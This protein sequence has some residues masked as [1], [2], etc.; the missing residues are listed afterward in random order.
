MADAASTQEESTRFRPVAALAIIVLFFAI[1]MG[2]GAVL[3]PPPVRSTN[4][5]DQFNAPAAR[6][7]L[8]RILG[9]GTPHPVDSAAADVTRAALL[10]EIEAL[11]FRPEVRESFI[12]RPQPR[13]PL[14]D[15]ALVRNIVFSIGPATGPAILAATHYDSVPAAPGASDAGIGIAAWLEIARLI[16]H[17][18]LQRRVIFLIG[19]GEEPGLL[20][21]YAFTQS[22]PL[23]ADVQALVNLEAR[24]T[25]GPAIFFE[26]NQPNGDAAAAYASAPRPIANSVMA[27]VYALLSNSTDVTALRRPGLDVINIALLDG[28]EGYHTPQDSLGSFNTASLQH[29]GDMALATTR[30]LARSANVDRA[31]PQV[32][33]DIASRAFISAPS[34]AAQALLAV[35]ALLSFAAFWRTGRDGRWRAFGAPV[36]GVVLASALVFAIGLLM[37]VGRPGQ[38]YWFAHAEP[39]RAVCILATLLAVFAAPT[40]LRVASTRQLGAAAGF[41]FAALGLALSFVLSGASIL[42]ML[43]A[44]AYAIG[45]AL[46]FIWPRALPIGAAA[47]AFAAALV[48]APMINLIE[49]ALG[50]E[51]P[52]AIALLM[53]IMA[54]TWLGAIF[55]ALGARRR[56]PIAGLGAALTV[57][58]VIAAVAPANSEARPRSLNVNYFLDATKGEGYVLAGWSARALPVTLANAGFAFASRSVLPGDIYETWA[59]PTDAAPAPTPSLENVTVS[60]DGRS[61][62]ATLRMNG[63]YRAILRMP[64]TSTPSSVSIRGVE[65]SFADTGGDPESDFV[66]TACQGRACDGAE[67]IITLSEP[68]SVPQHWFVIGQTPGFTTEAS[69]RAIAQRGGAATPIQFGDGAI[70]LQRL[71]IAPPP[72]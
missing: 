63:A 57:A 8:A 29:M 52:F 19:D 66:N 61:I 46:S 37:S 23:M 53:S 62:H 47:A 40:L 10:R 20:G 44:A 33:T 18:P 69:R 17:E 14:V 59:A 72:R 41:W 34:W 30:A 22:D 55:A 7:R 11:G 13:S 49:L 35:A 45:A 60:A 5:A 24:G 50:Y 56:W 26:S 42:F 2:A 43:P 39:M 48:W 9:N 68:L 21:A 65:A 6:E 32:Y 12:C 1:L 36:L 71:A 16:A 54:L 31:T 28:L 58:L 51:M 4:A 3:A 38:D 27:D 70:T 64:R 15:C 25:R 67:I